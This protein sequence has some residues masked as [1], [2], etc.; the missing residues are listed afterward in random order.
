MRAL[1]PAHFL[2]GYAHVHLGECLTALRRFDEAEAHLIAARS[3]CGC[4]DDACD[5]SP[6]IEERFVLL[7]EAWGKPDLAR[8][9]R[10]PG[11]AAPPSGP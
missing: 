2:V 3:A 10:P 11:A 7:Y 5:Y 6:V 8:Q 1:E 9:H 4:G